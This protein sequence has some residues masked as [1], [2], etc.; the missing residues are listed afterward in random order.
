LSARYAFLDHDGPIAFAHR[1]GAREGPENTM[2]AFEQAVSLGY[3]YLETDVQSTADGVLVA[4]HDPVLDRVT[5]HR[6]PVAEL[7]WAQVRAARV[8]GTEPIP[9]FAEVLNAWPEIRI[10]VDCKQSNAVE[11]LVNE[12]RASNAVDRV[13][14]SGF[15]HQRLQ[16]LRAE[17]GPSLCTAMSPR[18]I[19]RARLASWCG[20]RVSSPDVGCIQVPVR[21]LGIPIVDR[22]F[23]SSAHR[24]GLPVH[25]WTINEP[26]EMRRLLDLGVDGLMT[27]TPTVLRDVLRGRGQWR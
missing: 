25:V 11:P 8:A 22:R 24:A 14:I 5:D 17:L 18:Q 7:P 20:A 10:N 26:A 27:D 4:F 23:V 15:D 21:Q 13:C 9:R 1:G 19:V 12:L 16:R 6:G 2:R 3:R